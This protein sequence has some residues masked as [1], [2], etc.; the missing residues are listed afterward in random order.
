MEIVSEK[1]ERSRRVNESKKKE[2]EK[3]TQPFLRQR[4]LS[5]RSSS[6]GVVPVYFHVHM[7]DTVSPTET[8][9]SIVTMETSRETG[10]G[11]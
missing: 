3:L 1:V 8:T 4:T 5:N 2:L 9:G 10:G 7:K 11:T 6:C